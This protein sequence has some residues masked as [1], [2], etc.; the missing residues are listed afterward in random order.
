MLNEKDED[1][2]GK[3]DEGGKRE[4]KKILFCFYFFIYFL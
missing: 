4:I 1:H 3:E 2:G